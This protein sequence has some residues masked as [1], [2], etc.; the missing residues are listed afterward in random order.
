MPDLDLIKQGEQGVLDRRR[1]FA[2]GGSATPPA[3]RAAAA[4]MSTAPSG[5]CSPNCSSARSPDQRLGR[6]VFAA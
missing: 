5:C 1:R 6:G 2:R 3:G 4:T